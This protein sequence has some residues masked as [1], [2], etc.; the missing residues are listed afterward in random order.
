MLAHEFGHFAQRAG[1]RSYFLIQ[2]IQGW[3]ARVVYQRDSWDAWLQ[4]QCNARDWRIKGVAYLAA[5]LVA[6]SRRYLALLMKCAGWLSSAFSRQMAFDADRYESALIGAAAF[7][8]T[9]LR[10]PAL[11]CGA[12]LSWQ[13]VKR[14]GPLA[15]SP[16]T[17][18]P[19]PARGLRT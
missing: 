17:S 6:G 2:T 11:V 16:K 18:Q 5:G 3:F 13:D 8:Q 10:L 7:E 9:S 14:I 15:A 12:S 19:S 4:R 1:L